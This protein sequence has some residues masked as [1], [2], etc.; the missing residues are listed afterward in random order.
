VRAAPEVSDRRQVLEGINDAQLKQ[1]PRQGCRAGLAP[2]VNVALGGALTTMP[3]PGTVTV[4]RRPVP[5]RDAFRS[6]RCC[7][8]L[9]GIRDF[10]DFVGE[11]AFTVSKTPKAPGCC[12]ST[13]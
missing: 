1:A 13:C 8:R 2:P 9:R 4:T 5:R 10:P 3:P 11:S 6:L 7:L 12:R